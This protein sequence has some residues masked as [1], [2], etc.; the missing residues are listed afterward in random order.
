V[1]TAAASIGVQTPPRR[2]RRR[3]GPAA[4]RPTPWT[5][6]SW[7]R[8]HQPGASRSEQQRSPDAPSTPA[9]ITAGSLLCLETPVS[10]VLQPDTGRRVAGLAASLT[11]ATT[12]GCGAVTWTRRRR[13]GN[14]RSR[15]GAASAPSAR[16]SPRHKAGPASRTTGQELAE[17]RLRRCPLAVP[18]AEEE[19]MPTRDKVSDNHRRRQGTHPDSGRRIA[20]DQTGKATPHPRRMSSVH[21]TVE[22]VP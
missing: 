14:S 4:C 20:P 10:Y 17:H 11:W 2:P 1:T 7:R 9:I 3:S 5:L 15:S 21:A 16:P 8:P 18:G 12:T 13:S 22:G 19:S 6:H